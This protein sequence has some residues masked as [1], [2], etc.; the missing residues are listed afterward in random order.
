MFEMMR[1]TLK[2]KIARLTRR[3]AP[4]RFLRHKGGSAAVEFAAVMLPFLVIMFGIM[5]TALV[6]FAD[7]T[8]QTAVSD[9]ARLI[10]TG[11]AQS[12]GWKIDDFKTQVCQRIYALFD[13]TH[14]ISINVTKWPDFSSIH[15]TPPTY[16]NGQLDTGAFSY[17]SG[18]PGDIIVVQLYY[19]WP[20]F[21]T[22]G[23]NWGF[24]GLS[25]TSGP[26]SR[27]LVGV[28]AFKNEPYQ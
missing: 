22:W 23:S 12:G 10:M 15:F 9:S 21:M 2:L 3:A 1:T 17:D 19:Q 13:C 4:R 5:E 20:L 18:G 27:L 7:Q 6:F 11:Q 28:A 16:T 26:G 8:L 25:N 24:S 14:G